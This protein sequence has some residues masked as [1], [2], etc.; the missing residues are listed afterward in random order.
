MPAG[1]NF[2]RAEDRTRLP[3]GWIFEPAAIAAGVRIQ[4]SPPADRVIEVRELAADTTLARRGGIKATARAEARVKNKLWFAPFS[5]TVR[6]HWTQPSLPPR[7][8][9]RA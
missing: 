9:A 7:L 4:P 2:G 6:A 1:Q 8:T 5:K 3:A